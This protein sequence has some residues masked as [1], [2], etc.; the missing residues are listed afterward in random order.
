M[1][2]THFSIAF[3]LLLL[4]LPLVCLP[5]AIVG[6]LSYHASVE[7]VTR[8]SRD[9]QMRCAEA[10]AAKINSIFQSCRMDLETIT[11]IPVIEEYYYN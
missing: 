1:M 8:L 4:I 7:R 5:T 10:A 3:K 9:E 2:K 6:Y 11:C